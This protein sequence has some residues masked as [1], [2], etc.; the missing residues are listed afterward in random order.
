M[1][2]LARNGMPLLAKYVNRTWSRSTIALNECSFPQWNSTHGGRALL[3]AGSEPLSELSTFRRS[4]SLLVCSVTSLPLSVV[5]SIRL[6]VSVP[7]WPAWNCRFGVLPPF[8]SGTCHVFDLVIVSS[9][10]L[11]RHSN[12]SPFSVSR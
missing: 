6:S 11:K 9:D 10:G 5:S 1:S 4:S 8:F 3:R 12:L 2:A 7:G